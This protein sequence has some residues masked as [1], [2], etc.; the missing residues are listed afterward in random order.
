MSISTLLR[1]D[2]HELP[3]EDQIE[4]LAYILHRRS[5]E[6]FLDSLAPMSA[7]DQIHLN[8]WTAAAK[9]TDSPP[10]PFNLLPDAPQD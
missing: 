4:L 3:D 8:N 2:P 10:D 9:K 1:G 7:R 6:G 5:P